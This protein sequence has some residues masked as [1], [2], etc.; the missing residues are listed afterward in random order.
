MSQLEVN[1]GDLAEPKCGISEEDQNKLLPEVQ[2]VIHA[3]A[4]IQFDNPI[5]TDLK[6]SY[7]ATREIAD[8]AAKVIALPQIQASFCDA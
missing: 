3:A 2:F 4:N 7:I 6:L 5:Q 8:F 1:S